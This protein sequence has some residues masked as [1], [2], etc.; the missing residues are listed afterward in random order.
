MSE[1]GD[2]G[3]SDEDERKTF[4]QEQEELY[5][6]RFEEGYDLMDPQYLQ[7]LEIHW[8]PRLHSG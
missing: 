7:W 2:D 4:S 1:D 3:E 8:P 5:R 6:T